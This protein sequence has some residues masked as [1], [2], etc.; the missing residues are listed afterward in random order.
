MSEVIREHDYIEIM[1]FL[2]IMSRR[3]RNN[4]IKASN[5]KKTQ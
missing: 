4:P 1:K 5:T 3:K 2:T